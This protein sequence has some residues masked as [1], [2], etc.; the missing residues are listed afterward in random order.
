MGRQGAA[1][2][3]PRE[4]LDTLLRGGAERAEQEP[5]RGR[6]DGAGEGCRSG[7]RNG[8]GRG[9][10]KEKEKKRERRALEKGM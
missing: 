9:R 6:R 7:G 3:Q 4:K 2:G 8:N 1:G 5:E 10:E